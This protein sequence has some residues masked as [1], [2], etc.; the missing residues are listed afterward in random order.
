MNK[1]IVQCYT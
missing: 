1:L